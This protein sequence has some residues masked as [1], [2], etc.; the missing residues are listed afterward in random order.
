MNKLCKLLN[1]L[2]II[3]HKYLY[4]KGVSNGDMI[5]SGMFKIKN[6]IK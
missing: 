1:N 3:T 2:Q 5:Q 6:E 4:N